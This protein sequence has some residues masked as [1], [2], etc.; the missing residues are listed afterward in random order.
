[1][2]ICLCYILYAVWLSSEF[3]W[4]SPFLKCILSSECEA[5]IGAMPTATSKI[6]TFN[7]IKLRLAKKM[8]HL[9][10]AL[11]VFFFFSFFSFFEIEWAK[12]PHHCG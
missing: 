9:I 8:R 7:G 3:L 5:H 10:E 6:A 11:K 4:K 2:T 1:M 12:Y